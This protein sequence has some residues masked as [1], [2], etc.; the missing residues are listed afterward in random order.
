MTFIYYTQQFTVHMYRCRLHGSQIIN[1]LSNPTTFMHS[2]NTRQALDFHID[3]TNTKLAETQLGPKTQGPM[4][5]NSI[6]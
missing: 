5:W 2:Y 4:I 6:N 3:P 1:S